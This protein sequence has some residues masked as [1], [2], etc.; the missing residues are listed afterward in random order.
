MILM[1][2]ASQAQ[3]CAP[4]SARM[5][6]FGP[7]Y[8]PVGVDNRCTHCISG[9]ASDFIGPLKNSDRTI[10]GFNGTKTNGIKF[11]TLT[12]KWQDDEGKTHTFHIPN[13]IYVPSCQV[14][15]LSPQHW[16]Q[17]LKD[18][19][20]QCGETTTATKCT[21]QW[22]KGKN[23]LTIPL[24]KETNVATFPLAP[25]YANFH[26]FCAENHLTN[27]DW[28]GPLLCHSSP[29][30][31]DDED[32][33]P[34]DKPIPLENI[35]HGSDQ[36]QQS[37][38]LHTA[39]DV[40]PDPTVHTTRH[41]IPDEEDRT[42][43]TNTAKL[44][45]AHYNMGHAPFSKLRIMAK[46]GILPRALA[47]CPQP[48]CT[49]CEYARATKRPWRPRHRM[50]HCRKEATYPGE[51][52][53]VDQMVSPTPGLIGQMS[54]FLTRKRYRYATVYVDHYTGY[55]Y[56]HPQ[57][58]ASAEETIESKKAFETTAST[59]GI[60][61]HHY[62]ADNGIFRAHKWVQAC[63]QARQGL[64]YA[65]VGAHHQNGR[66]ERRIRELQELTRASLLHAAR[67]WPHAITTHLWPYALRM[68]N[69]TINITPRLK[70]KHG[71]SPLQAFGKNATEINTKHYHPFGCPIFT[72]E[73]PLQDGEPFHKWRA[74]ASIGIYLGQS[75]QHNQSVALVLNR[76]TGRVSPQF[77]V[78]FDN[79]FHSTTQLTL[80]TQWQ[81]ATGFETETTH[82]AQPKGRPNKGHTNK[83]NKAHA[84]AR[85]PEMSTTN[86]IVNNQS[87][88]NIPN[89]TVTNKRKRICPH[90]QIMNRDHN[91]PI[92][93]PEGATINPTSPHAAPTTPT[94]AQG[95]T[96][97]TKSKTNTTPGTQRAR[98]ATNQNKIINGNKPNEPVPAYLHKPLR[99]GRTPK[100]NQ[101]YYTATPASLPMEQ[102]TNESSTPRGTLNCADPS[103]VDENDLPQ[104]PLLA[105]KAASDPDTMYYHQALRQPDRHLFLKAMEE[106]INAQIQQGVYSL[107]PRAKLPANTKVIPAV[108]ALRRKRDIK[109]SAIKK[110]KARCNLDGSKMIKGLHYEQSYAPV[111]SWATVRLLLA[112]VCSRKWHTRQI[113]Y[114]LAY[115]QAPSKREIYMR[116]PPGIRF[117]GYTSKEYVLK[118]HRN[119][120]GGVDS[121][122]TWN[123]Y[124]TKK[125]VEDAGFTQSK[126]DPCVFYR[127]TVVYVL[128]TDDSI[129]AGPNDADINNT[130]K[131]IRNANLNITVEGDIQD[132]LGVN[133][134]RHKNDSIEL[135][136]TH[137]INKILQE[138]RISS[139]IH[140]HDIPAASS[141]ILHRHQSSP[142]HDNSF[143]YR[144][145][146][147]ML[148]YLE[149]GSRSDIAYATHQC[150]RFAIAPKQEH[151]SAVRWLGRYLAS[152]RNK[153]TI[154]QAQPNL[155]LEVFVDADFAGNFDK[156]NLYDPT[157]A[158]SRHGYIIRFDGCPIVWK[159]QLQ[160][161]I[162]L[163]TTEAEY[164][165]LS[166]ALRETIPIIHLL[167][168]L[169][170]NN[171][172]IS[173][174]TANIHC[175]VFEDNTGAIELA[176]EPKYRPRTKHLHTKLHHFRSYVENKTISIHHI[177]T[178]DQPADYLTKPLN[179][180]DFQRLRQK[181]MG[182]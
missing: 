179:I 145:L 142:P 182:W 90:E 29:V 134:T 177:D 62:H 151:A 163:S 133:I 127:G 28:H 167:Q 13:S 135:S 42:Q 1:I 129:L 159:S 148:N 74:R 7:T 70:D 88:G 92:L 38:P 14:R 75:P 56:V 20:E 82:I 50:N 77:H 86:N 168:E 143:H 103:P 101:K 176:R 150:A 66:A 158:R 114:V 21:L 122:R 180:E 146:V 64:T 36:W 105:F 54:G 9:Y 23:K 171:F 27:D 32:E 128:Y 173:P 108:W 71:K 121:G 37:P 49:A 164:T 166:Y 69:H 162:A 58:T 132:F 65:A 154:F 12:W 24:D 156:G 165:G 80:K 8:K 63:H 60:P 175:K 124:L 172:K 17:S 53:S 120:Y 95:N 138:L 16:A 26:S 117:H 160:T 131:A 44:L 113:D 144:S 40:T 161:Q 3:H 47:T 72:L 89:P 35:T 93:A 10:H 33:D 102:D 106:E 59:H 110:Y 115:P 152:T 170:E 83:Q 123:Q 22:N 157:T 119:L 55:G 149:K 96:R 112:I 61:I 34:Y 81:N 125:L 111:V 107:F 116:I 18:K 100:A 155:G 178:K 98:N 76:L 57:I 147:G 97:P 109:T 51:I 140:T 25:T 79:S 48:T 19:T 68:A 85:A 67:R 91:K 5:A 104:D 139:A 31:S 4:P 45:M 46:R 94:Q 30:I 43:P 137:L 52:V 153:G 118:V 141:K 78:R 126:V 130:I 39:F 87:K 6:N 136:Q 181:I 174:P 169:N 2:I 84:R 11:G 99:S 15:L 73:S 41:I